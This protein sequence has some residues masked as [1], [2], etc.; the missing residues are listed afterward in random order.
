MV[1]WHAV[2]NFT[3]LMNAQYSWIQEFMLCE[4]DQG[5]NA[6][7]ATKNI[8]CTKSEGA[9][10]HSTVS[11]WFKK[12]CKGCKNLDDKARS[13]RPYECGFQGCAPSHRGKSSKYQVSLAAHSL[14]WL[15]TFMTLVKVS[16]DAKIVPHIMKILQNFWLTWAHYCYLENR[17]TSLKH[18][19]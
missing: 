6:M 5:H 12:F 14:V 7:E 18:P 2:H 16:K 13:G 10:N 19:W 15:V 9:V 4:F 3:Y 11:R 17:I 1:H 8:C